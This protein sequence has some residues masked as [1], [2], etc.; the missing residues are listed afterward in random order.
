VDDG[1]GRRVQKIGGGVTHSYIYDARNV[2]QERLSS[3]QTLDYVQ[4]AGIDRAL[5]QRD[6]A[7]VVSYYLA[8]HLGSIVQTTN[9]AGAVTLTREDDP[10]GNLIQGSATNGYAFTGREWDSE[11]ALYNYRARQYDPKIGR[12]ISEDPAGFTASPNLF[13]YVDNA[14]ANLVD[15]L[16]LV[17]RHPRARTR[18][19]NA[20]E[21]SA[22][23]EIC[24]AK[25]VQSC[26]IS[27]TFRVVR[28]V[29]RDGVVKLVYSWVDGPMSCSCND[30]WDDENFCKKSP[31]ACVL[32][33]ILGVITVICT[34]P[35]F[36]PGMEPAPAMA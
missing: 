8:D 31:A 12:F 16:G 35:K 1:F 30:T 11:T 36:G 33:F 13:A 7:G 23:E 15:P 34:G 10:W 17:P 20:A 22:C 28:L 4:G 19:C 21:M 26:K 5:A 18:D 14:P 6:Q 27:Q 3:G 29:D 9:G 32:L 2:A 25:G 24:G